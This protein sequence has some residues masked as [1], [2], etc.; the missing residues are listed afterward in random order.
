MSC[1][2]QGT[3]FNNLFQFKR[4]H[5]AIKSSGGSAVLK[6]TPGSESDGGLVA[7]DV[8]VMMMDS[9][10]QNALPSE[11]QQWVLHVME[12]LR[13]FVLVKLIH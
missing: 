11:S 3:I 12:T 13:R 4:V 6:D 10:E 9:K 7:R 1:F 5:H 2:T 8:C